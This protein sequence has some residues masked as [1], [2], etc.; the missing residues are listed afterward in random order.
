MDLNH[1]DIELMR[2]MKLMFPQEDN[3]PENS[4][5]Q[6]LGYIS[7][8]GKLLA[9]IREH[10]I[11]PFNRYIDGGDLRTFENLVNIR[12]AKTYQAI[13]DFLKKIVEYQPEKKRKKLMAHKRHFLLTSLSRK[14]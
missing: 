11:N 7:S 12:R 5:D 8:Y 14:K 6:D 2:L 3:G 13:T 9:T 4:E 1:R 10:Y